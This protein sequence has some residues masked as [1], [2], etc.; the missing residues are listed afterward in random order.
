MPA[1]HSRNG[2]H[3]QA[4]ITAA[5]ALEAFAA[6]PVAPIAPPPPTLAELIRADR[7]AYGRPSIDR[8][9]A[10]IDAPEMLTKIISDPEYS[11]AS[12]AAAARRLAELQGGRAL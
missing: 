12:K 4:G 3:A 9:V 11:S 5:A 2:H 7:R 6:E 8:V 10:K 1:P